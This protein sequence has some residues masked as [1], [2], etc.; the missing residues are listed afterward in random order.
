[1]NSFNGLNYFSVYK[2]L[3]YDNG[4]SVS[5]LIIPSFSFFERTTYYLN[6]EGKLRRSLRM[7]TSDKDLISDKELFFL[8]RVFKDLYLRH[9]YSFFKN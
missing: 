8:L 1:M 6:I 2:G 3:F 7:L 4:A 5:N 9:N